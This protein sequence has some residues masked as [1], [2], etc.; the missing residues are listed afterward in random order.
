MRAMKVAIPAVFLMAGFLVCT[1][2][3]YGKPEYM[4]KEG[5]KTCTVCHGKVEAKEAM[6]KNLNDTGKCYAANDH[7]LAKCKVPD[8]K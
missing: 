8:K 7:S 1:T 3:S 6:A 2:S 5:V 4:K